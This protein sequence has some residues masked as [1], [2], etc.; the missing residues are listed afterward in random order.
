MRLEDV[1]RLEDVKWLDWLAWTRALPKKKICSNPSFFFCEIIPT[2]NSFASYTQ[3]YKKFLCTIPGELAMTSR[4]I[5]IDLPSD[6]RLRNPTS[7]HLQ[8]AIISPRE[9]KMTIPC[10]HIHGKHTRKKERGLQQQE[11]RP[12]RSP[13]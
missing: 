1:V 10:T 2:M 3:I 12:R 11:S 4:D 9:N 8:I 6:L 7:N 13:I 5:C